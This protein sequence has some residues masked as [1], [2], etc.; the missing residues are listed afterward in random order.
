LKKS[1]KLK[2]IIYVTLCGESATTSDI[3]AV[4]SA[5]FLGVTF[6]KEKKYELTFKIKYLKI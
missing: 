3:K 2:P 6:C 1:N 5:G 4:S